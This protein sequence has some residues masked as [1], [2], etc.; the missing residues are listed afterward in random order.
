MKWILDNKE[1]IFSGVGV[2]IVLLGIKIFK[3][4]SHKGKNIKLKQKS[5]SN[6]TN[7]Q[8]GGD[9]KSDV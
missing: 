7:I 3:K 4:P 8:I 9:F 6:S 1:W 5:G 2:A